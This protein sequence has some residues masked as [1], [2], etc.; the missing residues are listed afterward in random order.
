VFSTVPVITI[1]PVLSKDKP[2]SE[3]RIA[4]Y[5]PGIGSTKYRCASIEQSHQIVQQEMLNQHESMIR[6]DLSPEVSALV[7]K[8]DKCSRKLDDLCYI[9]YGAQMS[10]KEKGGFGKAAV[11]RDSNTA[12]DCRRMVSGRD[13][14]RYSATWDGKYVDWSFVDQMYGP[15]WPGFFETAKLMIRDITGTH[16]IEAT[17]DQSGLYCDHTILCALR[18]CDISDEKTF[19]DD[20]VAESAKY[21]LRYLCGCVASSTLSA[22]YYFVLTG[23]GVRSGGGFHT[24][25]HTIRAFPI[26]EINFGNAS[27]KS[28]HDKLVGL[29]E[30]MLALHAQ[31][32]KAK[33]PSDRTSL[34]AQIDAT[35][36]QID[37]LVYDLYGLTDEEVRIVEGT[38]AAVS[39]DADVG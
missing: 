27:D 6:L 17:L 37:R 38:S 36:R 18:K 23:E 12:G 28:R 22:Y 29:V 34:Q 9:N 39:P 4:V 7:A 13:V 2:P 35:D 20:E 11:I 3:T 19:S 25:P 5:R 26:R 32:G 31:L 1:I 24:Y 21:D 30:R 8:I 16:R 10:S 14:Y 33:V 15:R